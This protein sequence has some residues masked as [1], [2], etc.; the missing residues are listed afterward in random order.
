MHLNF[1]ERQWGLLEFIL[2][3]LHMGIQVQSLSKA[4][5]K[6]LA[7]DS[8]SFS[9]RPGE[10]LGFLGPNG[11]GKSTTMKILSCFLAPTSGTAVVDGIDVLSSPLQVRQRLGYL[12]E[13][14]PLYEDM[15]V[16]E[17]LSFIAQVHRVPSPRRRVEELVEM[18]GLGLEQRKKIGALSKGYRQRVGIA[19]AIIHDPAV[20]ILDEPTSGL[21]PAQLVEIRSLIKELGRSKTV[22]LSTH[23]MQEAAML[24]DRAV[25]IDRGKIV[26]DDTL[27]NLYMQH[28]DKSLEEIFINLVLDKQMSQ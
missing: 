25:I 6:Q 2:L 1:N 18:T 8:I 20:L 24:C 23:I 26:A 3:P 9:A 4:Y 14:N 21:D 13:N 16:R 10:I 28:P 22:V 27:E 12:A 5:G 7:I 19:Q 17:F 11:A 15:Y